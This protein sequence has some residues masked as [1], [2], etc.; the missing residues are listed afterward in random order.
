MAAGDTITDVWEQGSYDLIVQ[1]PNGFYSRFRGASIDAEPAVT[2]AYDA[3]GGDLLLTFAHDQNTMFA[4]VD[5]YAGGAGPRLVSIHAGAAH[6]VR[7]PVL[8]NAGWFDLSV[9]I[10]DEGSGSTFLRRFCGR[11]ETGKPS[12]SDPL[13]SA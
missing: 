7:W 6:T 4:V 3:L 11:M 8:P 1:G 12:T 5:A 2:L 9:T 13:L 10:E